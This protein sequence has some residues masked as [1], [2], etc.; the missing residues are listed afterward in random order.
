MFNKIL[1]ANRGEIAVR[2]IRACREM[3]IATVAVFSEADRDAL[4]AQLAD[5][6]VC[7]G[8]ARARDS[9]LHIENILSAACVTRA[10]AIHPGFGFLSENSSFADMCAA[11]S[12]KFI[13][14][15][16]AVIA[17]LGDKAEAKKT[18]QAAGVPVIPG[19]EGA[20][21]SL[22]GARATAEKLGYPVLVKAA[23]G[24]G[25]RGIRVVRAEGELAQAVDAARA[26]AVAA[27]GD[28]TLYMEKMIENARHIEI[29]LL[30]DEHGH[31]V[32]LGERD[33]SLQRRNQKV[34]EEAP[35]VGIT[36]QTRGAMG[37]AA[38]RAAAAVG[39]TNAGTA[40]FLLDRGGNF[41]FMEMNTRIQV[42]HPVTEMVT[43]VDIVKAQIAI[44]A[45]EPLPFTQEGVKIYGHAIE[46][47]V[48]AEDAARGFVPTPGKVEYLHLPGGGPG[49]RVDSAMYA[50]CE[51]PPYYD[52]MIAKVI[53]H[54]ATREEAIA[55]LRRGLAEFVV[56]GKGLE[57]N[58]DFQ[59]E[60]LWH[61]AFLRGETDTGFIAREWQ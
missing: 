59:S 25:G 32:H 34:L 42:E 56:Q 36:P 14:P 7:V 15:S 40:E 57:T 12:I 6:A 52:S 20:F 61:P 43:G 45:G 27:F 47:R 2:V 60:L 1:I 9:Y 10:E 8:P 49:L 35:G 22:D 19:S 48:N 44:A 51:I 21:D 23:A 30:G 41:Y 5:E 37:E 31:I 4:H 54:G 28:G 39:Y 53:A 17:R 18:M 55:K 3:G 33:C 11:C 13:G 46:C 50:G 38:C 16:A 29:Q 24:G 58:L 26:E